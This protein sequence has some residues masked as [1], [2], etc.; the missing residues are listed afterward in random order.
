MSYPYPVDDAYMAVRLLIELAY[1]H[2]EEGITFGGDIGSNPR[3]MA[4]TC[5]AR[6]RKPRTRITVNRGIPPGTMTLRVR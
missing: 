4:F 1:V 2:R 6:S 3:L 5:T